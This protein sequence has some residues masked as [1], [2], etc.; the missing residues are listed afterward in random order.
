VSPKESDAGLTLGTSKIHRVVHREPRKRH[1]RLIY[2]A[3][4]SQIPFWS[5]I[6]ITWKALDAITITGLTPWQFQTQ[7]NSAVF[8]SSLRTLID[9][10]AIDYDIEVQ[11]VVQRGDSIDVRYC[12]YTGDS[13]TM[14][15]RAGSAVRSKTAQALQLLQ[16]GMLPVV[17]AVSFSAAVS[18]TVAAEQTAADVF[19]PSAQCPTASIILPLSP[20]ANQP[21][22]GLNT[23]RHMLATVLAAAIAAAIGLCVLASFVLRNTRTGHHSVFDKVEAGVSATADCSSSADSVE[24]GAESDVMSPQTKQQQQPSKQHYWCI[25]DQDTVLTKSSVRTNMRT[26]PCLNINGSLNCVCC[27]LKPVCCAAFDHAEIA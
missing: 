17:T 25:V 13:C 23:A 9:C 3:S 14:A 15:Y 27:S 18:M 4:N 6:Q 16:D 11:S 20:V 10:N 19:G 5:A 24:L 22:V 12:I 2:S 8:E 26:T 21:S 1:S 7:Q